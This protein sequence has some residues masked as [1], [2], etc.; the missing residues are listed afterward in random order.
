MSSFEP[1]E[2]ADEMDVG[3]KVSGGFFVACCNAPEVFDGV[4]ETL[5]EIALGVEREVAVTLD[6]AI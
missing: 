4:E 5:D 6:L 2:S 3:E 1:R